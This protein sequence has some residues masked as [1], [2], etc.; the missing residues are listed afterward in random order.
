MDAI[1]YTIFA[2]LAVYGA[3]TAVRETVLFFTGLYG[4]DDK[5]GDGCS[6]CGGCKYCDNADT[7]DDTDE[8]KDDKDEDDSDE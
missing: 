6:L 1:M 5:N 8:E 3:Y 2:I 7:A 4:G